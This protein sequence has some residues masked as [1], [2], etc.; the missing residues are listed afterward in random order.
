MIIKEI[1]EKDL[2]QVVSIHIDAFNGFFLTDLGK[3]FLLTYYRSVLK[4]PDGILLGCY[5]KQYLNGFCAAT[6]LSSGFNKK[7]IKTNLFD[8]IKE[9]LYLLMRKPGAIVRLFKNFKKADNQHNDRGLYSELLSIG[10]SSKFQGLGVGKNLLKELELKLKHEQCKELSLTTDYYNNEKAIG[11]Y[12][13]NGYLV[14]YDFITYPNRRMY[15]LIKKI[16]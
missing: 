5:E 14:M 6:K 7:L 15:R 16:E 2:E 3:R 12:K 1:D 4:H 8:Y 9:G 11:F 13:N 10:V